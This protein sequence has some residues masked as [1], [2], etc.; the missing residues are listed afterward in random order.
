MSKLAKQITL[1]DA[2]R[3]GNDVE[4]QYLTPLM[5]EDA[6]CLR[7]RITEEELCQFIEDYELNLHQTDVDD[8]KTYDAL[9]YLVDQWEDVK[10]QYWNEFLQPKLELSFTEAMAYVESFKSK[11]KQPMTEKQLSSMLSKVESNYGIHLGR[12]AA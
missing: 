2:D 9:E 7:M 11:H 3:L 8:F 1:W 6:P 10:G 12:E 4:F 5:G